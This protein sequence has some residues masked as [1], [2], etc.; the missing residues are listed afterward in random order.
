[1]YQLLYSSIVGPLYY[2]RKSFIDLCDESIN[3][4]EHTTKERELLHN[5]DVFATYCISTKAVMSI[6]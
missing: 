5:F 2:K 1:M 4:V 3:K 6:T